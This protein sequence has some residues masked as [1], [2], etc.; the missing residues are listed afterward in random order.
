M[1]QENQEQEQIKILEDSYTQV[2]IE[3]NVRSHEDFINANEELRKKILMD[4]QEIETMST[5]KELSKAVKKSPHGTIIQKALDYDEDMLLGMLICMRKQYLI[6]AMD[7][8]NN[9]EIS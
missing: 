4:P 8:F 3:K 1:N 6:E 7:A 5:L 2:H 9:E